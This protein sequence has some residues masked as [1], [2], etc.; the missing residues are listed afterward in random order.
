MSRVLQPGPAAAV[1]TARVPRTA[2]LSTRTRSRRSSEDPSATPRAATSASASPA[3]P[4]PPST[5]RHCAS[6]PSA[7]TARHA[8][9]RRGRGGRRGARCAAPGDDHAPEPDAEKEY[10]QDQ[11]E[12]IGGSSD[13]HHEDAGPGDFVEQRSESRDAEENEGESAELI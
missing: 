6:L 13:D 7:P 2:A 3:T 1:T 12:R 4:F 10:Q 11:R 9:R 5:P 8:L